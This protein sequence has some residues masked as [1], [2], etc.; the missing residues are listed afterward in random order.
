M[1]S[2]LHFCYSAVVCLYF[3]LLVPRY[4]LSTTCDYHLEFFLC[5]C[6][7]LCLPHYFVPSLTG[8]FNMRRQ[9][10][11]KAKYKVIYPL[12]AASVSSSSFHDSVFNILTRE[13]SQIL[14]AF[15]HTKK[16]EYINE[17]IDTF[18]QLLTRPP[19]GK[20][21]YACLWL[22]GIWSLWKSAPRPLFVTVCKTS[23]K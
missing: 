10:L 16:I 3:L 19:P 1:T 14:E 22:L 17:S 23:M 11:A 6:R 21:F 5:L 4:Y 9:C 2:S 20:V 7:R 8:F 12:H 13:F 15:K 18:C